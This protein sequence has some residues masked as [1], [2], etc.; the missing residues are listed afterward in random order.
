MDFQTSYIIKT[1]SITNHTEGFRSSL[2]TVTT[3]TVYHHSL[4][5]AIISRLFPANRLSKSLTVSGKLIIW[6]TEI[7]TIYQFCRRCYE[8]T[9]LYFSNRIAELTKSTLN[10][11]YNLHYSTPEL[12]TGKLFSGTQKIE[13]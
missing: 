1:L 2:T 6:K 9:V 10:F 11:F 4:A 5:L 8:N 12:I 13:I 7:I 3:S